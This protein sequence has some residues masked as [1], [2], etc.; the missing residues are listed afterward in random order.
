MV[1]ALEKVITRA[2]VSVAGLF[3][4][5]HAKGI[6][7]GRFITPAPNPI[8]LPWSPLCLALISFGPYQ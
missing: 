3:S 7:K 2:G 5:R 8:N 6:F 1:R 4:R